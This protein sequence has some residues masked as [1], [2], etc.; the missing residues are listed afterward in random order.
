MYHTL[1]R[2]LPVQ[3]YNIY[4]IVFGYRVTLMSVKHAPPTFTT[5]SGLTHPFR[6]RQKMIK[7]KEERREREREGEWDCLLIVN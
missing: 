1:S 2:R 3:I 6:G 4:I 5:I 7:E